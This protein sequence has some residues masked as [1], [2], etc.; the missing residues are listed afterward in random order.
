MDVMNHYTVL[1][2]VVINLD[3]PSVSDAVSVP[4]PNADV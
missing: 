1:K 2:S 4:A 3:T